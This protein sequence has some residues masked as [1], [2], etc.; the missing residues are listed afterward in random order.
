MK[1]HSLC[2]STTASFIPLSFPS[3]STTASF[4]PRTSSS[5]STTASFISRS[6]PSN[7]TT[8]TSV[9]RASPHEGTTAPRKTKSWFSLHQQGRRLARGAHARLRH[10]TK[11]E[12]RVRTGGNTG[13]RRLRL[14]GRRELHPVLP[15]IDAPLPLPKWGPAERRR[16][17]LRLRR[18]PALRL[19]GFRGRRG[20]QRGGGGV[21]ATPPALSVI[22]TGTVVL[23][24]RSTRF[25]TEVKPG[26]LTTITCVPG[27]ARRARER[28]GGAA[29]AGRRSATCTFGIRSSP[30]AT[31]RRGALPR[32]CGGLRSD[33]YSG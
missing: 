20:R 28:G 21:G 8:A 30:T 4:V 23:S 12:L 31:R 27:S 9:G 26:A 17:S 5:R 22:S 15:A 18:E 7:G 3:K 25:S 24:R 13:Q 32:R 10:G 19:R 6:S 16:W 33:V 11:P 29:D 1:I 14:Q 2:T